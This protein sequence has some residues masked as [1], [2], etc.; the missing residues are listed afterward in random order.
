MSAIANVAGTRLGMSGMVSETFR[1]VNNHEGVITF[2][3]IL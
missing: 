1:M 2:F 3:E